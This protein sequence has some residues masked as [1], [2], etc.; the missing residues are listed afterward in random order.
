MA[1][2][3]LIPK[4][5]S[6]VY[7]TS[8]TLDSAEVLDSMDSNDL[9]LVVTNSSNA[10]ETLPVQYAEYGTEGTS[11]TFL[12]KTVAAAGKLPIAVNTKL[13]RVTDEVWRK[14]VV[15]SSTGSQKLYISNK[16]YGSPSAYFN[17]GG[18]SASA[19]G[20]NNDGIPSYVQAVGLQFGSEIIGLEAN[21]GLSAY[22]NISYTNNSKDMSESFSNGAALTY[23]LTASGDGCINLAPNSPVTLQ[24][25]YFTCAAT[26]DEFQKQAQ[27]SFAI[28]KDCPYTDDFKRLA[29]ATMWYQIRQ[30]NTVNQKAF[31]QPSTFYPFASWVR[32]TFWTTIPLDDAILSQSLFQNFVDSSSWSGS[33]MSTTAINYNGGIFFRVKDETP[34]LMLTWALHLKR[35]FNIDALTLAQIDTL[36]SVILGRYVEGDGIRYRGTDN[37]DYDEGEYDPDLVP[38]ARMGFHDGMD[39][40]E[41]WYESAYCQ[42]WT[43]V[44]FRA[45]QELGGTITQ[46]NLDLAEN[47]Y[48]SMFHTEDGHLTTMI[49]GGTDRN[50]IGSPD[51]MP[52]Y[53]A[54][55]LF[56][57]SIL[58][59]PIVT[60]QYNKLWQYRN[61]SDG[62]F[63]SLC[64]AEDGGWT[65]GTPEW[66]S[67]MGNEGLNGSSWLWLD[68][69]TFY[70]AKW[71]G[72]ETSASVHDKWN[73]RLAAELAQTYTLHEFIHHT[74]LPVGDSSSPVYG[75]NAAILATLDDFLS[76]GVGVGSLSGVLTAATS[77]GTITGIGIQVGTGIL[78]GITTATSVTAI[79]GAGL[80][81]AQGAGAF[82]PV[83]ISSSVAE[84]T[85]IGIIAGQGAL[86]G[87][88]ATSGVETITGI[89]IVTSIGNQIRAPNGDIRILRRIDG[90][91]INLNS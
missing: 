24:F 44:A 18:S 38:A 58:G 26:L 13:V 31:C 51:L 14:E 16:V 66:L 5:S 9:V 90:T 57:T 48:Q 77:V 36:V 22:W 83:A 56:N 76:V 65:I 67:S 78:S 70:V 4:G 79:T 23:G 88:T 35:R 75:W 28:A 73:S 45:A 91:P 10:Q 8:V 41:T 29:F 27:L 71:H 7:R 49:V 54:N 15:L 17:F 3:A 39:V 62:G 42:G 68:Y 84:I 87:V 21:D 32:D 80:T 53:F 52:E 86:S 37:S 81:V 63:R 19:Q 11:T 60:A 33:A 59:T 64:K 74:A 12:Q 50:Y 25:F 6:G 46:A 43:Y 55:W 2:L 34:M 89:G 82:T 69:L 20:P 30:M 72:I 40:I 61:L 1:V 85:G 47:A